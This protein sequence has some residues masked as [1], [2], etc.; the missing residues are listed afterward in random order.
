MSTT[1]LSIENTSRKIEYRTR[2][3]GHGPIVRLM[4]PHD[5]G[6]I[7]KPFV[8][9]DLFEGDAA[10]IE[11]MPMHPHSGIATVTVIT[12]GDLRFD[13]PISGSGFIGYGGVEWMRAG[14]GVWHGK[15]MSAGKSQRVRGYQL[16]VA[17]PAELENGPVDSQYIEAA[18]MPK[19]GPAYVIVGEHNGVKSP[20]RAQP[21]LNYLLVTLPP[22]T[23]WEYVPPAGHTT[24]WMSVSRGNLH[25][26]EVVAAG[27]FVIFESGEHALQLRAGN[28]DAVFV[29]GSAIP[30]PHDLKLGNYSVHTS[31]A[32]LRLGEEKI[33]DIGRRLQT[34]MLNKQAHTSIPIF[35]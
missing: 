30:H 26:S 34:E 25:S 32:A 28:E 31:D 4:S 5:Y 24:L 27:E 21:G 29:I 33:K 11:R 7:A 16:W 22:N 20:V 15:E 8:F 2:G 17:L 3:T 10:V 12:E 6:R 19:T 23:A 13:D 18:E 1:S 9:L 35:K 14:G